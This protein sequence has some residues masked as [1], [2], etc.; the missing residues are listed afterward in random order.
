MQFIKA[1]CTKLIK[2]HVHEL[3]DMHEEIGGVHIARLNGTVAV[4]GIENSE[5]KVIFQTGFV[6]DVEDTLLDAQIVVQDLLEEEGIE[7]ISEFDL[8]LALGEH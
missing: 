6:S 2:A 1:E 5:K 8:N 7:A 4:M 3:K